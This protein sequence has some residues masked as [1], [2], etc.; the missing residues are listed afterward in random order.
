MKAPLNTLY[1]PIPENYEEL[2]EVFGRFN[3]E[4]GE[5]GVIHPDPLWKKHN[6]VQSRRLPG[7]NRSFPCHMKLACAFESIF[8]CIERAN[9]LSK[10]RTYDGCYVPRHKMRNPAKNLSLHSWGIAVD[11]NAST[12]RYGTKGDID[13]GVIEIFAAHGFF[14]GGNFRDPMHF[15]YAV[16]C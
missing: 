3:F 15:Q 16:G 12:N 6:I 7:I 2:V 13:P 9:L 5:G 4:S 11:L 14:W 10:I 1:P 8:D